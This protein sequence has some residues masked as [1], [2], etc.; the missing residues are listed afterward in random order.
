MVDTTH[1]AIA[2]AVSVPARPVRAEGIISLLNADDSREDVTL[3][4]AVRL[5]DG[6]LDAYNRY[7]DA[8]SPL[9][10]EVLG[11]T[12]ISFPGT[13]DMLSYADWKGGVIRLARFSDRTDLIERMTSPQWQSALVDRDASVEDGIILIGDKGSMPLWAKILLGPE[14]PAS[15]FETPDIDAMSPQQIVDALLAVY[16]DGGADPSRIQLEWMT[17]M[18]GFKDRPIH[19]LNLYAF[20]ESGSGEEHDAY[21]KSAM[22]TVRKYGAHPKYRSDVLHL[23]VSDVAWSRVVFVRWPSMRVMQDLRLNPEYLEAQK[24]RVASAEVYGNF[25]THLRG[26]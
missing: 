22:S 24:H 18:P 14:R 19:Y 23:L 1:E 25:V 2:R 11:I 10:K 8:T 21:N 7:L 26:D 15:K 13:G 6:T 20:G 9:A 5:K 12:D 4:E 16:P 17:T 3:I